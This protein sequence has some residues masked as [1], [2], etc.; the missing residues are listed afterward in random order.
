M[1]KKITTL[2]LAG[3]ILLSLPLNST[4]KP[5]YWLASTTETY[6][7]EN[8]VDIT[9]R[10]WSY[11]AV[12]LVV[13]DL[14][15]MEPKTPTRFMGDKSSTRYELARAF[16][17][18]AKKLEDVSKTD[19]RLA[20][21]PSA[22]DITDV[23][24]A[25][26]EIVNALINEY[27]IMQ[28]MPDNRFMGNREMTRYELAFDLNNY[29]TIL[30][31]KIGEPSI[32]SRSRVSELTDISDTHW[33]YTAVKNIVDKY[34]IMDGYPQKVF[35][36]EQKLTRYEVAALLKRFV[37]AIDK[38]VIPVIA[39]P[40][41][42]P[43]AVPTPVPTVRPTPTPQPSSSEKIVNFDIKAGGSLLSLFTPSATVT[44]FRKFGP[45]LNLDGTIWYTNFGLNLNTEYLFLDKE[46]P[47]ADATRFTFGSSLN[48][49]ALNYENSQPVTL[50]LG[51]GYNYNLWSG[52]T[53]Y[54]NHGPKA[55]VTLEVPLLPMLGFQAKESFTYFVGPTTGFASNISWRNDLF[56]GFSVP[57]TSIFSAQLGYAENRSNLNS[58]SGIQANTRFKF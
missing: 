53:G 27:G 14:G 29:F 41:P 32:E 23:N 52:K 38:Y 3:S 37:E 2:C 26:M 10:H 22:N 1:N 12:K 13:E 31:K 6:K 18:A 54:A 19:L 33:A 48:W 16:Y 45:A 28:L 58:Q 11:N 20:Q 8:L 15:I 49:K 44:D 43:T 17:R 35:G 51:L 46:L 4:A 39:K 56:L 50:V 5:Y 24:P 7:I 34:K 30:E 42:A 21:S 9:P 47:V 55:E 36:G 40:T 57:V 25:N